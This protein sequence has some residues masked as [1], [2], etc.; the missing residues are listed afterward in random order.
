MLPSSFVST[1][2]NVELDDEKRERL[3]RCAGDQG[4]DMSDMRQESGENCVR[5]SR[6]GSEE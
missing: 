5:E 2:E 6:C 3:Q 1:Q 4:W